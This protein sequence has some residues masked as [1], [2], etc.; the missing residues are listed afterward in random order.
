MQ[1]V[2]LALRLFCRK[3]KKGSELNLLDPLIMKRKL[4]LTHLLLN[5]IPC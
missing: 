3:L 2:V 4:M 1:A 5:L